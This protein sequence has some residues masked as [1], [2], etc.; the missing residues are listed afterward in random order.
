MNTWV[1]AHT[2]RRDTRTGPA[3][4]M[5]ALTARLSRLMASRLILRKA[6]CWS[7]LSTA[8][9]AGGWLIGVVSWRSEEWASVADTGAARNARF[10]RGALKFVSLRGSEGGAVPDVRT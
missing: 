5:C 8:S 6:K 1:Q 4:R 3:F 9:S 2:L 7:L 10:V